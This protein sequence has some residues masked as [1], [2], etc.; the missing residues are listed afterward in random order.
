MT[1]GFYSDLN[2]GS[3]ITVS[4]SFYCKIPREEE[5]FVYISSTPGSALFLW[6]WDECLDV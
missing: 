5:L 2:V 6:I 4:K 1:N 3:I